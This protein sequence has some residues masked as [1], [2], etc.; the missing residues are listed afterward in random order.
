MMRRPCL[1]SIETLGHYAE[2]NRAMRWVPLKD[3]HSSGTISQ[4][5]YSEEGIL[6]CTSWDGSLNVVGFVIASTKFSRPLTACAWAG[7]RLWVGG[8]EGIISQ[9]SFDTGV[10]ITDKYEVGLPVLGLAAYEKSAIGATAQSINLFDPRSRT[11]E[12]VSKS[13]G[14]VSLDVVESFVCAVSRS[15]CRV[16]DLRNLKQA[17]HTHSLL[18]TQPLQVIWLEKHTY[19]VCDNESHVNVVSL[20][21]ESSTAES[22]VFKSNRQGPQLLPRP[23]YSLAT[24]NPILATGGG[25]NAVYLWD[26]KSRKLQTKIKFPLACTA[27]AYGPDELM[28]VGLSNDEWSVTQTK[29]REPSKAKVMVSVHD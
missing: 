6:A 28:A 23:I 21:T 11:P 15:S 24:S 9:A 18:K 7:S 26:W 5:R 1:I 4:L 16:F 12:P 29:F 20:I 25:D 27:L 2:V 3:I 22:F 8:G 14:A 17:L 19:A 10:S 13:V